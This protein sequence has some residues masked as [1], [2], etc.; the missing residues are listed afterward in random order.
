MVII[1]GNNEIAA[2][3]ICDF[4][5]LKSV[6]GLLIYFARARQVKTL[7][8]SEGCKRSPPKTS[9]DLDPLTSE[10][11]NRAA[12]QSKMP[13]PYNKLAVAAKNLLSVNRM[14]MATTEEIPTHKT[15]L[16]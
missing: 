1:A 10:P 2:P 12:R 4:V 14:K 13:R 8:N 9:H 11:T 3:I 6:S 16:P 15:C 5:L 7:D